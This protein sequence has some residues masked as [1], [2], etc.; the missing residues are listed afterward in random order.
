MLFYFLVVI[1]S[2]LTGVGVCYYALDYSRR[3]S[4][5][6]TLKID[7]SDPYDAP[8]LFSELVRDIEYIQNREYVT[9]KVD[10]SNYISQY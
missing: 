2:F 5:V 8:Y 7:R 4:I 3:K 6:G 10:V 9:F 1:A